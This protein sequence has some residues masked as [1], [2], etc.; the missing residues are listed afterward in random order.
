MWGMLV[1]LVTEELATID[2]LPL[3]KELLTLVYEAQRPLSAT[4]RA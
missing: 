3:Y 2:K 4:S 1:R